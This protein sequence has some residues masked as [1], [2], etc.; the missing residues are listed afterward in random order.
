MRN[1][2]KI[3]LA[4][5]LIMLVSVGAVLAKSIPTETEKLIKFNEQLILNR[6]KDWEEINNTIMALE[7]E[8]LQIEMEA[9]MFRETISVLQGNPVG[10]DFRQPL[11]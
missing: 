9:D 6:Q 4:S 7:S 5:A 3:F 2:L 1:I 8:K 10:V 11:N